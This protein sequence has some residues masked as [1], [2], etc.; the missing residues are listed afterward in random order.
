[1]SDLTFYQILSFA[2]NNGHVAW[3]SN[4]VSLT[5]PSAAQCWEVIPKLE[6]KHETVHLEESS[7]IIVLLLVPP[8]L[9]R[10]SV[11]S[12]HL[13]STPFRHETIICLSTLLSNNE[14]LR[15]LWIMNCAICGDGFNTL[16]ESL[17]NNTSLTELNV[18]LDIDIT[19]TSSESLRQ[20]LRVNHTL[21]VLHLCGA[22]F[23]AEGLAILL[24]SLKTNETLKQLYLDKK[25]ET[26][27]SSI[28]SYSHIS[29]RLV[30]SS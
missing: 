1:M 26:I 27:C 28:P 24:E 12:L 29:D 9:Q 22:N 20:L 30:F 4:Q 17:Q 11:K 3:K 25:H 23:E 16:V 7:S 13:F 10:Q 2:D 6:G 21:N 14:S 18:Q 8:V 5:N 15:E 19:L